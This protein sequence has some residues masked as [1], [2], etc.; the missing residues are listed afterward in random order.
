VSPLIADPDA[1]V[2][3]TLVTHIDQLSPDRE[4]LRTALGDDDPRVSSAARRTLD[5]L[6]SYEV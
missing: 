3:L 5:R 6:E 2:R 1:E 4:L